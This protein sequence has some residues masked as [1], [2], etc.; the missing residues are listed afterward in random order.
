MTAQGGAPR[1][2][3]RCIDVVTVLSAYLDD[4]LGREQRAGID[5]HLAGCQGCRNALAQLRTVKRLTGRLTPEDVASIEPLIR[6]RL[7]ATLRIP[8]RR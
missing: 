2:D 6:D 7:V 1:E 5:D 8:R 3:L 4:E